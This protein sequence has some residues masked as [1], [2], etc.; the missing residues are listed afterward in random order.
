MTIAE[1]LKG[2][3]NADC[4]SKEDFIRNSGAGVTNADAL[5]IQRY[6]LKLIDALN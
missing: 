2:K 5:E 3:I 1:F 4:T 6:M